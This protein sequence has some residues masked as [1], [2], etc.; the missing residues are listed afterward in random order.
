MF[1]AT[2]IVPAKNLIARANVGL[3]RVRLLPSEPFSTFIISAQFPSHQASRSSHAMQAEI[4]ARIASSEDAKRI[5]LNDI[6]RCL[7][8]WL[9]LGI[10]VELEFHQLVRPLLGVLN[11]NTVHL[12]TRSHVMF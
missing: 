6:D 2:M 10:R 5:R 3:A 7:W 1:R 4:I 8:V 12:S 11:P 9:S